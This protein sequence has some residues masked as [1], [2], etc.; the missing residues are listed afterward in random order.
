MTKEDIVRDMIVEIGDNPSREG[1]R[2]TPGRVIRSWSELYAGYK[3]DP[4]DV[5]KNFDGEG[6]GGLVY[7]KDIE[8]YS[9]CE[10]HMLPFYGSAMIAYIP[11][12]KIIGVSKLAR[13]LDVFARRLQVQE[14]IGEQVTN[15]LMTNLNPLGAACLLE[16]K[17]LC[18]ACRGV[19]KQHS[20]M[21]YS[22]L[23]GV[24]LDHDN[25]GIAA[26]AELMALW[27]NK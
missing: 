10:H 21:G 19:R 8:F 23:K 24:F 7:L 14:R 12:G 20:I 3:Q 6:V 25:A 11:N 1:L 22:S 26:R 27:G 13:L 5:F 4:A 17:H 2:E 9:T 16:A 15:A 18:I